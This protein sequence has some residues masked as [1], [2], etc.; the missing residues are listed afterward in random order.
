MSDATRTTVPADGL[1]LG[2]GPML[3]LVAAGCAVWLMPHPWPE[4]AI[5][6]ALIWGALILAFIGGVR[7]GF[8]FARE[9]ASKPREIAAAVGY[10]AVA[11]LALVIPR[12]DVGLAILAA[13]YALA[14]LL[15]H[16]AALR[17]DA[18]FYFAKL[19]VSQLLLGS[20]GLAACSAWLMH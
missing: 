5:R 16:R 2:Y 10:V 14:A 18:P 12:A 19:R 6:C 17:G 15:D 1:I 9:T 7:R 3:P 11:G 4:T 20:A 8:G 13:G